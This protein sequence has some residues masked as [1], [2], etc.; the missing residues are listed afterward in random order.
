[1]TFDGSRVGTT[2]RG[3]TQKFQRQDLELGRI[4]Y[5][6]TNHD[7]VCFTVLV[8]ALQACA[9]LILSFSSVDIIPDVHNGYPSV[10]IRSLSILG[11]QRS[12]ILSR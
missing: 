12:S 3:P 10:S 5:S 7:R 2:V 9:E 6:F 11:D 8:P 4:A 1:M